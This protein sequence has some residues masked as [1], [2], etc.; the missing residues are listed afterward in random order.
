MLYYY[1]DYEERFKMDRRISIVVILS[2]FL[3]SG[4]I[5]CGDAFL[6]EK[7]SVKVSILTD[8]EATAPGD[9]FYLG[10]RFELPEGW[11]IYWIN[12]GAAGLPTRAMLTTHPHIESSEWL[13]PAPQVF[14]DPGGLV[15]FGYDNEVILFKKMTAPPSL[16]LD[17]IE[18]K[19]HVKWLA[20]KT[21][22]VPGTSDARAILP[23]RNKPLVLEP[24]E[25]KT[26]MQRLP[27]KDALPHWIS[28]STTRG[29]TFSTL[30]VETAPHGHGPVKRIEF[31]PYK[32]K[33]IKWKYD[34]STY[35]AGRYLMPFILKN[36]S[37]STIKGV[38]VIEDRNF[39]A[40]EVSYMVKTSK[41]R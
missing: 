29:E 28:L 33:G 27:Q 11:H 16:S 36:T 20:C 21:Y 38:L 10:L 24:P 32:Q 41:G 19:V 22:C 13:W 9:T 30:T 1:K 18:F 40:F 17:D 34:K 15:T 23:V 35:F 14:R 4:Q 31:F 7:P 25:F 12:S 3:I 6:Q 2:V 39:H 8:R 26:F 5:A 37:A